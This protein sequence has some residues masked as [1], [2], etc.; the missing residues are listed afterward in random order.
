M[1]LIAFPFTQIRYHIYRSVSSSIIYW[2]TAVPPTNRCVK[3]TESDCCN[4]ARLTNKLT[5][6]ATNQPTQR[7]SIRSH[8]YPIRHNRLTAHLSDHALFRSDQPS[9]RPS[10]RSR[11]C[12][13]RPTNS[14]FLSDHAL[15]RS[16]IYPITLLSDHANQR[17]DCSSI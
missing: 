5:N 9:H 7:Q 10:I 11:S 16:L 14:P 3:N 13:M 4:S 1:R 12:P 6:K 8:S 15:V 17:S 2:L